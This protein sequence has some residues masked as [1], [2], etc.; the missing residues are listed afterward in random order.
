ME[1]L[2]QYYDGESL[3]DFIQKVKEIDNTFTNKSINEWYKKQNYYEVFK[4]KKDSNERIVAKYGTVGDL[5]VDLLDVSAFSKKNNGV[6]YFLV[7]VDVYSRYVWMQELKSKNS[8][9]VIEAMKKILNEIINEHDNFIITI[10][11]DKGGEFALFKKDLVPDYIDAHYVV[12]NSLSDRPRATAIVERFNKTFWLWLKRFQ[13]AK[14]TLRYIDDY[15]KMVK[16]YNNRIHSTLGLK[17]VDVYKLKKLY[18]L[19]RQYKE[20]K[21]KINDFVRIQNVDKSMTKKSLRPVYSDNIYQV[22]EFKN[23]RFYL[24]DKNKKR[25]E[26]GYLE[27]QLLKTNYT[28]D[29]NN[30]AHKILKVDKV[31]DDIAFKIDENKK[32]NTFIRKQKRTV[33]KGLNHEVEKIDDEGNV[34]FK[35]RLQPMSD[36]RISKPKKRF[37]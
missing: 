8:N 19:D 7:C 23:H 26:R 24:I 20:P 31:D 16:R 34:I 15:D 1:K 36:K 17:P 12:N 28:F 5:Q 13:R 11:S 32:H 14:N 6:K 35:K 21:I 10:T 27:N 2:E 4:K 18:T 37:D 25:L 29:D 33:G 3:K 9:K 30:N 22:I